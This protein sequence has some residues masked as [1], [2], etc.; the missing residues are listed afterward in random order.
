[1]ADASV[2]AV[3][4]IGKDVLGMHGIDQIDALV[5]GS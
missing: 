2:L 5:G 4:L 3:H 1:M